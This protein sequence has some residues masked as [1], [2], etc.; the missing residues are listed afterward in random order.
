M[1]P[2]IQRLIRAGYAAGKAGDAP[3]TNPHPAETLGHLGWSFGHN[4]ATL[5]KGCRILRW[6][7]ERCL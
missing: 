5:T 6:I 2:M 4:V 3:G 7:L 1:D